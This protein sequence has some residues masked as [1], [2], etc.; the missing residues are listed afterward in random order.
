MRGAGWKDAQ[1]IAHSVS[2]G[3][4][5]STEPRRLPT[6]PS[7]GKRC[8]GLLRCPRMGDLCLAVAFVLLLLGVSLLVWNEQ[9]E[10][11]V[12]VDIGKKLASVVVV[13]DPTHVLAENDGKLVH[14]SGR[15]E[16]VPVLQD[17]MFTEI[18]TTTALKLT[19]T[20][21]MLQWRETKKTR[22]SDKQKLSYTQIWSP[23]T[24]NSKSF[25][26]PSYRNPSF[27]P[28]VKTQEYVPSS[29]TVGAYRIPGELLK[30]ALQPTTRLPLSKAD[31]DGLSRGMVAGGGG[32]KLDGGGGGLVQKKRTSLA[33][34]KQQFF[35]SPGG[36]ALDNDGTM[37]TGDPAHPQVGDLRVAFYTAEH[38]YISMLGQ[39]QGDTIVPSHEGMG[40]S[41][42]ML[43]PG[44]VT[45][46]TMLA[47]EGDTATTLHLI[48][49]GAFFLVALSGWLYP[50]I[51][52]P[53]L[54]SRGPWVVPVL[55]AI[56]VCFVSAGFVWV[57][58]RPVVA[59]VL[60]AVAMA[61]GKVLF[62]AAVPAAAST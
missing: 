15:V 12:Y 32:P 53:S 31:F 55:T 19:R 47:V 27:L 25:A 2:Q 6:R 59:V 14:V 8:R 35:A 29:A 26:D 13:S 56:T 1:F 20:V 9:L 16:N 62:G 23:T 5:H 22:R 34:S 54:E 41:L 33:R 60:F 4:P 21:T 49:L 51:Q 48:R 50:P 39:Q 24:I 3:P 61:T 30:N 44:L 17:D 10:S 42:F 7:P 45:A 40:A 43:R 52:L 28:D 36:V 38:S 11:Q 18:D 46:G 37:R 58:V 57:T